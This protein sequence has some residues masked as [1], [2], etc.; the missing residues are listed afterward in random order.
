MRA[1]ARVNLSW[2]AKGFSAFT[3]ESIT[4][5]KFSQFL[6][7]SQSWASW[8]DWTP[9]CLHSR[10]IWRALKNPDA[11][12][13]FQISYSRNSGGGTQM[14]LISCQGWVPEAKNSCKLSVLEPDPSKAKWKRYV[15]LLSPICEDGDYN[16]NRLNLSEALSWS[17]ILK[18]FVSQSQHLWEYGLFVKG[19]HSNN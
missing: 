4:F 2:N 16:L 17:V 6:E 5:L 14:I 1:V 18:T 10:T 12:A 3:I 7:P 11:Q 19:Q 9:T 8:G 13:T 15:H